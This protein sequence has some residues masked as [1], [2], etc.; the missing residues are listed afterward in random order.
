MT[1]R[2]I[3]GYDEQLLERDGEYDYVARSYVF[4]PIYEA[5]K[6]YITTQAVMTCRACRSII[7]YTGGPGLRSICLDC[8]PA[9]KVADFSEGHTHDIKE[10]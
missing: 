10:H 2:Q 3:L 1:D 9:L 7:K 5:R 4:I 8:Y 6:G